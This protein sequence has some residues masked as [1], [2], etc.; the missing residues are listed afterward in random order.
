M[1][2]LNTIYK[3]RKFFLCVH[4]CKDNLIGFEPSKE[5]LTHFTFLSYGHGKFHFFYENYDDEMQTV[6]K[7]D[8]K[9]LYDLREYIDCNVVARSK[10]NSKIISFNS[11]RKTDRWE[12][13]LIN[14]N[15][16]TIQSNYN[17]SCLVCF[18]GKCSVNNKELRELD[19]ADLVKGREYN[20]SLE[21]NCYIGLFELTS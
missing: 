17:Y 6:E 11:W 18:E 9:Q 21:E 20:I 1:T 12:G 7:N 10:S 2:T 5:R 13:R 16:K 8:E 14:Y 19:V 4:Q 15:E 3:S